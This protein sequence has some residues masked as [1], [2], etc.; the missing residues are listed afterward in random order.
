MK[1][2]IQPN[3]TTATQS[4]KLNWS[5]W[6]YTDGGSFNDFHYYISQYNFHFGEC[7]SVCLYNINVLRSGSIYSFSFVLVAFF[8]LL[9]LC[10]RTHPFHLPF[11]SLHHPNCHSVFTFTQYQVESF[12]F[13]RHTLRI[14]S[15]IHLFGGLCNLHTQ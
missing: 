8:F 15:D 1:K 5:V 10:T 2:R 11:Y 6:L 12:H 7:A 3:N 13:R 14:A 9:S 4:N